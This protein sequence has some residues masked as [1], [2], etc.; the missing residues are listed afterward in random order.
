MKPTATCVPA[1]NHAALMVCSRYLT[2]V[3]WNWNPAP[4]ASQPEALQT[5]DVGV[6]GGGTPHE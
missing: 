1:C 6:G 4:E 5:P 3:F 2:H